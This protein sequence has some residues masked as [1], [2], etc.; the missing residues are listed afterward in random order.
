VVFAAKRPEPVTLVPVR[1]VWTLAL[2]NL[3][4]SPAAFDGTR[5][6]FPIEGDRIAAYDLVSGS[7]QWIAAGKPVSQPAAGGDMLFLVEPD[8]LTALRAADGSIAW[9]LPFAEKLVARPVFDNG[10]LVAAT[11]DGSI[12]AFRA[13][14]GTLIWRRAIGSPV[15]APPALAADRVYVPTADHRL[16]ALQVTTG[17]SVWERRLGGAPNEILALEDRLYV[18]ST[19]NFFYC[20]M[21]VDGR[22]DWRWRTGGDVIGSPVADAK[23]V[24]FVALDNVVRALDRISGGQRWLKALPMRPSWGPALATATLVVAGQSSTLKAFTLTDGTAAPDIAAGAEVAGPL[25]AFEDPLSKLPSLLAITRDIA[26]GAGATLVMRSVEPAITP[27]TPLANAIT[28]APTLP[29]SK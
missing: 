26:K 21:T 15:H 16:I 17:D 24:Y 29:E 6:Y 5:A 23:R 18:G 19:D 27:V 28:L 3:L 13:S 1:P 2:N 7:L 14:D 12:L 22:V 8:A 9:Q 11:A 20:L 4:T 10:W 25:Y